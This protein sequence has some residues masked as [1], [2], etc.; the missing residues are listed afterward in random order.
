MLGGEERIMSYNRFLAY[1]GGI[2]AAKILD[3]CILEPADPDLTCAM[4]NV[5]VPIIKSRLGS[6][7]DA[8]MTAANS[9]FFITLQQEFKCTLNLFAFQGKIW[10]RFSAQVWLEVSDFEY[11][12][13]CLLDLA[14]RVNEGSAPDFLKQ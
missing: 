5:Q 14:N 12:A 9:W 10:A 1:K 11:G 7:V 4:V 13:R 8:W 6:D 2:A 3:T